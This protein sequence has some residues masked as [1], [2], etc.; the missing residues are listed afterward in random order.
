VGVDCGSAEHYVAVPADR[1]PT[2]VRSFAT[3]T[4]DL[5]RLADWLRACRVTHVAMEATG[6]YWIPIFEILE[7]RGFAVV[8]RGQ[9]QGHHGHRPQA[10]HPRLPYVTLKDGLVYA[11]P[12]AEAYDAQHRTHVVR[13][14]RPRAAHLGFVLVN[15]S[16]GELVDGTVS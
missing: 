6:V 16:T 11:D 13:R 1:D 15:S 4:G 5:E 10:R 2:S 7:A 8:S 14:L 9:D 3:F 12:G